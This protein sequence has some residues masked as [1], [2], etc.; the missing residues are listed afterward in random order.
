MLIRCPRFN[1]GVGNNGGPERE[2]REGEEVVERLRDDIVDICRR[3]SD[4]MKEVENRVLLLHPV[5]A[6]SHWFIYRFCNT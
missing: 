4:T 6:L 1:G 3:G 2:E 5:E